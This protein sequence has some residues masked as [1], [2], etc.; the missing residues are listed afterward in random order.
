MFHHLYNL[1]KFWY[2]TLE[3]VID[4]WWSD[5]SHDKVFIL[6]FRHIDCILETNSEKIYQMEGFWCFH[7]LCPNNIIQHPS[8]NLIPT[9]HNNIY[10]ACTTILIYVLFNM[11]IKFSPNNVDNI[12]IKKLETW[13]DISLHLVFSSRLNFAT[14]IIEVQDMA[15]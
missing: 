10:K 2:F 11:Q 6:F 15:L 9:S 5:Q 1:C 13:Y 4:Q 7:N 12:T 14:L 3:V 8:I